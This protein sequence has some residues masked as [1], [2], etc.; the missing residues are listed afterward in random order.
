M[1]RRVVF[2]RVISGFYGRRDLV[3][4]IKTLQFPSLLISQP[5]SNSKPEDLN[6]RKL[7]S[8]KHASEIETTE[9]SQEFMGPFDQ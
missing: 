2:K 7:I 4:A 9:N 5:D 8:K 6:R 1:R 3:E